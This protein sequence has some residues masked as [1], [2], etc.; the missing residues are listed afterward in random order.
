MPSL[1]DLKPFVNDIANAAVHFGVSERTVRRWL[2]SS[3]LTEKKS[4]WGPK[5]NKS[6]VNE[7]HKLDREGLK[8]VEIAKLMNV[9]HVAISKILNGQSH[10]PK[11]KETAIIS[12]VY[13]AS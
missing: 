2:Q 3:G 5:L 8:V 12:V 10:A 9:S 7:V 11:G 4:G 6:Q 13:N 1:E